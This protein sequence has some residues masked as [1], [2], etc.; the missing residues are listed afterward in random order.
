MFISFKSA[1]QYI[2]DIILIY[3]I[4]FHIDLW[5]YYAVE[6]FTIEE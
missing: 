2:Q 5:L 1:T 4:Y 6:L 3:E